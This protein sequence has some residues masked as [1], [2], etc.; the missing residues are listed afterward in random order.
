MGKTLTAAECN[1]AK[2]TLD[3]NNNAAVATIRDLTRPERCFVKGS[4]PPYV[5]YFN[6]EG[7]ES[8]PEN[9]RICKGNKSGKLM[10]HWNFR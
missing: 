10:A 9:S 5:W 7:A 8:H 1:A 2:A 4:N 3:R 6:T